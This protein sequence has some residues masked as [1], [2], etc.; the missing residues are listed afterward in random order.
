MK[1]VLI[2]IQPKWCELIA[3]GKKT[4]EVRKTRPKREPPFKCYIYQTKAKQR[5]V[6][7]IKDGDENYGEIYH[8]KPVFIKATETGY[9]YHPIYHA[10]KMVI[11]EFSCDQITSLHNVCTDDWNR[12]LGDTHEWQK[13]LVKRACLTELD[14]KEYAKGKHCYAWHISNLKIYEQPKELSEFYRMCSGFDD[15]GEC[16]GCENAV[17]EEFDCG[18][19]GKLTIRRPPQSWCYVEEVK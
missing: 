16:W 10:N 4:I 6:E 11:G 5:L 15:S 1:S 9:G 7:V 13:L 3:S 19:N 12:L 2:S 14:L 8:G 18:V 17:G